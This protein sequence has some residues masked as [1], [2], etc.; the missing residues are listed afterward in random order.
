LLSEFDDL[1]AIDLRLS[2]PGL[3]FLQYENGYAGF[4][5]SQAGQFL[6]DV[7]TA[8]DLGP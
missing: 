5:P 8:R 1:Q 3:R 4:T 2:G 7:V 6:K